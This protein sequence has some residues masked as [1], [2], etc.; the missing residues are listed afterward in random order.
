MVLAVAGCGDDNAVSSR[1]GDAEARCGQTSDCPTGLICRAEVCVSPEDF[2]PPDPEAP[3][4]VGRPVASALYLFTLA[5]DAS[6]LL[7]LDPISLALVS[8][9]VPPGPEGLAVVPGQEAVLVLSG[10][11]RALTWVDMDGGPKV[12]TLR[13]GRRYR[14]VSVSPDGRWAVLWTPDGVTPE[15]GAEGLVAF[16]ELAGLARGEAQAIEVSAGFRNTD[17]HFVLEGE[18]ATAAVVLSKTAATVVRLEQ[19][20]AA[21]YRP[22]RILLPTAFAE[23]IGREVAAARGADLL[24]LRSLGTEALAIIDVASSTVAQFSLPGRATDIDL[25][26]DGQTAVL[27][28]R[29]QGQVGV[30]PLQDVLSSTGSLRLIDVPG[31]V[32]GQVEVSANGV[33]AAVFSTQDGSERFAWLNLASGEYSIRDQIEKQ[34]RSIVLTPDGTGAIV[35]HKADPDSTVADDYER[36]VD[37][38][39]GYS[40]VDLAS[41][42]A[43]LKRTAAAPALEVAFGTSGRFAALT[44]RDETLGKYQVDVADFSSLIVYSLHLASSPQFMGALPQGEKVWVTQLHPAG[45]IS[46]L[47]LDTRRLQTL[48][49]FQLNSEI[50]SGGG[51]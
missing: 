29:G 15:D 13:L 8:V 7:A 41:G 28:L 4:I 25:S 47:D 17:V 34:V 51:Q 42:F 39:E 36:A 24:L 22:T 11:T 23:V 26:P 2:L 6:A 19:L 21:D 49:G 18:T 3:R 1:G 27:A 30:L 16:V 38:D 48:T 31:I 33:H 10:A 44:L 32:P 9:P 45:R 37:N 50:I 12:E 35:L 40:L 43:Q 46:V 5:V 20:G 14:E